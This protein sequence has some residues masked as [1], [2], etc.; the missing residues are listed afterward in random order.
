MELMIYKPAWIILLI[1]YMG[2]LYN[3]HKFTLVYFILTGDF[4]HYIQVLST[5]VHKTN[6]LQF[7]PISLRNTIKLESKFT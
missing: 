3:L 7:S 5:Q 4:L 1:Y 6:I 2:I